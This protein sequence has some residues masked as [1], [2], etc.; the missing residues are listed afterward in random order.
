MS[1]NN[2]QNNN[3][4]GNNSSHRGS[5]NGRSNQN[6]RDNSTG[7][8][9]GRNHNRNN[10]NNTLKEKRIYE[11]LESNIFDCTSRKNIEAC[12]KTLKQITI[13]LGIEFSSYTEQIK[14]AVENLADPDLNK[15]Q[16]IKIGDR[17]NDL[18]IFC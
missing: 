12:P 8:G 10:N 7:R 13:H 1:S 6:G 3:G 15:A 5:T 14:Y 9:S 17:K 4:N 2:N 18:K 11:N 16:D